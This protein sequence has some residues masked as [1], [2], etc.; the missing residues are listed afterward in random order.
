MENQQLH[1][2]L[3]E[4]FR[5]LTVTAKG[6]RSIE[7]DVSEI[8]SDVAELKTDVAELKID[9]AELKTDVSVLKSDVA[10][11]KSDVSELKQN[12]K[13]FGNKLDILSGQFN[14]VAMMVFKNDGR[15]SKVELD[16]AELKS[17]VH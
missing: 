12:D 17:N 15:L 14:D 13:I 1:D 10:E 5:I 9:V 3:D 4:F 6:V 16:V 8:K 11:L 2:R 7:V